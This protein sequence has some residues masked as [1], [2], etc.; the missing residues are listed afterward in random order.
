MPTKK[1]DDD[2]MDAT[3]P[4]SNCDAVTPR[5]GGAATWQCDGNGYRVG[6]VAIPQHRGG[7]HR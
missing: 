4:P 1:G 7:G 3:P 6:V 5:R 2:K